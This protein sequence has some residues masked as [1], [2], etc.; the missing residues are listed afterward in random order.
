MHRFKSLRRL[1]LGAAIT[2]AAI[3]AV[4]AMANASST[5][6]YGL[7]GPG[8]VTLTATVID[9]SGP[10][11]LRIVRAGPFIAIADGAQTPRICES[12]I[13]ERASVTNTNFINVIGGGTSGEDAYVL[14][15]TFG[16]FAPGLTP[17]PDGTSE[18]ETIFGTFDQPAT[19]VVRGTDG[20]DTMRV[21]VGGGVMLGPDIDTD[22]RL[23]RARSVV[24]SG[25]GGN[26]FL[27]GRGG[28][29][30]ASPRA[31]TA[32]VTLFG[33]E[34]ND[35]LVDG[36]AEEDDLGGGNGD[37]I[38]FSV[39]G[40]FDFLDG[41]AGFDRATMDVS[42]LQAIDHLEQRTFGSVGRLRLSP[43]VVR[44]KHGRTARLGLSW[45]HPRSWR[46]LRAVRVSLYRGGRVVGTVKARPG[47]ARLTGTGAVELVAAGSKL[48]HRGK[49]VT[50]KL[51]LRL[52]KSLAGQ[53]LRVD[54][55]ATDSRGRTQIE[56]SA[57]LIR[58]R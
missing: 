33:G 37:D 1:V 20:A 58:V 38:L 26:D 39:D 31:A 17:E 6:T 4:P 46:D 7:G 55:Q 57:G 15:Q 40:H 32:N 45:T 10:S 30:A 11:Q 23:S 41:G 14:D 48:S 49:T 50:A 28:S 56:P 52:P 42:D 43:A 19:L 5:C 2:G 22:V 9:G 16:A 27:S 12:Q 51:A 54:V 8:G 53:D 36:L 35:T 3:G 13:G 44:A 47:S 34:G 21:G 24:L 25:R 29:P 18:I